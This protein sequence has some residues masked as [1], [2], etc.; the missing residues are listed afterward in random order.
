MEIQN[1]TTRKQEAKLA[2]LGIKPET[3]DMHRIPKVGGYRITSEWASNAMPCWSLAGLLNVLPQQITDDDGL[4]Y[5][6]LICGD[7]VEY[8]CID[9]DLWLSTYDNGTLFD[10]IIACIDDC[11]KKGYIS[12]EYL[13]DGKK[14]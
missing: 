6:R 11:I 4:V 2:E 13:N 1:C 7:V 8:R 3:A 14:D 10:N 9:Y 12:K 5:D